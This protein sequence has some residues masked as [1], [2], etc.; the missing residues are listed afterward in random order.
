M[1]IFVSDAPSPNRKR[2]HGDSENSNVGANLD[3][4]V[5][6]EEDNGAK[7]SKETSGAAAAAAKP[8]PAS[9]CVS[10]NLPIPGSKGQAAIVKIYDLPEGTFSVNDVVEFVGIISLN[11]LL[12]QVTLLRA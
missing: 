5:D 12:A 2:R 10:L 1:Y 8:P 4:E 11:P 6:G 3:M 9:R 7:K